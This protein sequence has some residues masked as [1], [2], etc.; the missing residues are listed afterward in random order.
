[1]LPLVQL[2]LHQALSAQRSYTKEHPYG[3]SV[4]VIMI[5]S[6]FHCTGTTAAP[7]LSLSHRLVNSICRCFHFWPTIYVLSVI[8]NICLQQTALLCLFPHFSIWQSYSLS[9]PRPVMQRLQYMLS[10]SSSE[11]KPYLIEICRINII[12]VC[13]IGSM[14]QIS[15]D[16]FCP[17]WVAL[18]H[19]D[20]HIATQQPDRML[21][22]GMYC[23]ASP[24][25][26]FFYCHLNFSLPQRVHRRQCF[27]TRRPLKALFAG[28]IRLVSH[29][30]RF[31]SRLIL[32][33]HKKEKTIGPIC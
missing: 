5:N 15:C 3:R 12:D 18:T 29:S 4:N 32:M 21:L 14:C 28:H 26:S 20:S 8:S 19:S 16:Q 13:I 6:V 17:D 10:Q 2:Q 25:F 1:M 30:P 22:N 23:V 9:H 7:L 11:R 27:C 31:L 33:K 24:P